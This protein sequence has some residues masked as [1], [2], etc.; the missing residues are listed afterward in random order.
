MSETSTAVV[1]RGQAQRID[2]SEF[3]NKVVTPPAEGEGIN[4]GE[5]D[6]NAGD[7]DLGK[8]G[9][10]PTLTEDQLKEYFASQNIE[11]TGIDAL[12]EKLNPTQ[13]KAEPT[14]EEI[15]KKNNTLEKR[16]LDKFIQG[17]GKVEDFTS[18]KQ[19]LNADV[20][21][22]SKGVLKKELLDAGFDEEETKAIIKQRYL[23]HDLESLVFDE[24][25]DETKEDFDKRKAKLEKEVVY[26]AGQLAN[27][28]LPIKQKAETIWNN[29]KAEVELEDA[30]AAREAKFSTQVD[31]HVQSLPKSISIEIG[32]YDNKDIEPIVYE[33]TELFQQVHQEV[34]AFL[35]N[36][37]EREKFFF[38]EEGNPNLSTVTDLLVKNKILEKAAGA[39][40]AKGGTHQVKIF[41]QTFPARKATDLGVGGANAPVNKN[42]GQPVSRGQ[43]QKFQPTL[44]T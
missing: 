31:S 5:G 13:P 10:K 43:T 27:R 36:R 4:N 39:I 38:D 32:K 37:T 7:I 28:S 12:K 30:D 25:G 26:G 44:K 17:G 22:V 42:K 34:S 6:T 40:F 14:P 29:L 1:S 20:A 33:N 11:Y 19:L 24:E 15:E 2:A 3:M 21:E 18:V 35:K 41:E 23:Q 8:E 9:A 16:M